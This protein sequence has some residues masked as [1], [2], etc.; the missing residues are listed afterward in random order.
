MVKLVID[1][2]DINQFFKFITAYFILNKPEKRLKKSI[3]QL[4]TKLLALMEY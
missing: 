2:V 4:I 1:N 3:G